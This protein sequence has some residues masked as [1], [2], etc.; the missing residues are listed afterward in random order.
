MSHHNW[1]NLHNEEIYANQFNS[2][3][4]RL[5]NINRDRFLFCFLPNSLAR[6]CCCGCSLK[7]GVQIIAIIFIVAILSDFIASI[8][9][10]SI[11]YVIIS[12][13]LFALY[14]LAA[15]C[16]IYSTIKYNWAMAHTGYIIYAIIFLLNVLDNLIIIA[17]ILTGIYSPWGNSNGVS[18]IIFIVAI[19]CILAIHLYMVWIVFS[20]AIHL[21]HNRIA[22]IR[23]EINVAPYMQE[24]QHDDMHAHVNSRNHNIRGSKH[25]GH[26]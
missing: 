16:I 9:M 19:V 15:V 26:H 4:E 22:L 11:I 10:S 8:S 6:D 5:D 3:H 20:F 14:L 18:L 21:K 25:G 23:G 24:S 17:L 12:G 1:A 2:E 7:T 13:I